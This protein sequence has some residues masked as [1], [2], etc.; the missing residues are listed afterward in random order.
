M[1]QIYDIAIDGR[2]I[3]KGGRRTGLAR[4]L[5]SF[6]KAL[7]EKGKSSLIISDK[8]TDKDLISELLRGKGKFVEL[9]YSNV[10]ADQFLIP[11]YVV[12]RSYVYFSIYPK[13]PIVLPF[14]GVK[15]II[16]IADMINFSYFQRIF[17]R[18]FS[19]FPH[20]IITISDTWKR[21]IDKYIGRETI[22]I[23][24]DI[25][26]MKDRF[27]DQS[28]DLEVLKDLGLE[29]GKY[30]LYVGNFNP[31]KN[32]AV[33][34]K[35]FRIIRDE[36]KDIKLVLAGGGGKAEQ[37]F[38]LPDG[39]IV[40]RSPDDRTLGILYRN[41]LLFVFPSF[42]EGLGIPPLEACY[43]GI[44]VLVSDIDVFREIV[45]DCAIFFDPKSHRDLADK[46]HL[47]YKNHNFRDIMRERSKVNSEKF[48]SFNTG[49]L[50][51]NL[52][53]GS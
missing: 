5:I 39:C 20:E 26:Y 45:G 2:E 43:F 44:P 16:T 53:F 11:L 30:I 24:S 4:Y 50:I 18:L 3:V 33:L 19:G 38:D 31:H 49:F 21:K 17:L 29:R 34:V 51:Y 47:I 37:K 32:V 52:I 40:I 25:L 14:F 12:G 7:G 28:S 46:M 36:I 6:M 22:R 42:S 1:N 10:F 48:L 13:F 8:N 35:A 23:Y 27:Y 9:R 41:A 15:V